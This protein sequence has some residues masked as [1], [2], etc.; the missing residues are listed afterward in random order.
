MYGKFFGT[1]GVQE[2]LVAGGWSAHR[3]IE[4]HSVICNPN[5]ERKWEVKRVQSQ[6]SIGW[7]LPTAISEQFPDKELDPFD[8]ILLFAL[9]EM[10]GAKFYRKEIPGKGKSGTKF[11]A[12]IVGTFQ[13]SSLVES[14]W[15]QLSETIGP[16]QFERGFTYESQQVW[17]CIGAADQIRKQSK[18]LK[19]HGVL[20]MERYKPKEDAA[21]VFAEIEGCLQKHSE[22]DKVRYQYYSENELKR[23]NFGLLEYEPGAHADGFKFGATINLK[24]LLEKC[25]NRL[26]NSYRAGA[27]LPPISL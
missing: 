17:F 1:G 25:A 16:Q 2:A 10:L 20:V 27:G 19:D 18:E 26:G 4:V 15:K 24:D 23:K 13:A 22:L 11:R 8:E 14:L 5:N 9:C 21:V 7:E 12:V 6:D 3:F